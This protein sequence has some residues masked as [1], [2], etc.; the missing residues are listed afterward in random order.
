MSGRTLTESK[1]QREARLLNAEMNEARAAAKELR[2]TLSA[3][4]RVTGAPPAGPVH[5][6]DWARQQVDRMLDANRRMAER[7]AIHQGLPEDR[8]SWDQGYTAGY[9]AALE[10]LRNRLG[11]FWTEVRP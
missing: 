3:R 9:R 7:D 11:A 8:A 5:P 6:I 4:G 2:A 10:G 1:Y